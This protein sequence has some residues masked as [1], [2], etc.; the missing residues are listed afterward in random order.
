MTAWKNTERAIARLIGGV[1]QPITGRIRGSA[2]DI[3]HD[4]LSVEVKHRKKLP[5][6]LLD[7]I[8][9]A[10]K[11]NLTGTKLPIV[12]LHKQGDR[13]LDALCVVR[14]KDFLDFYGD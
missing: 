1:R 5:L 9:Q 12:I 4:W 13:Y 14:L 3:D 7:A 6:W 11:S 2:P 10:E 8:D